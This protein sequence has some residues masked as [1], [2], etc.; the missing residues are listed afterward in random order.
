M[1]TQ[2]KS[3]ES[4]S[5]VYGPMILK[6]Q[7]VFTNLQSFYPIKVNEDDVPFKLK[8]STLCSV[9]SQMKVMVHLFPCC[10][11]TCCSLH[12]PIFSITSCVKIILISFKFDHKK[13]GIH[14][15][16][17]YEEKEKQ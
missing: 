12:V 2:K 5:T 3:D 11:Q 6:F 9:E 17:E 1:V 13:L 8:S 4:E 16:L 15:L 7:D 10:L 14:M